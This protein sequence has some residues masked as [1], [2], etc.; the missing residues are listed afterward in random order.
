MFKH[1]YPGKFIVFEGV[2]GSGKFTQTRLLVKHLKQKGFKTAT[3]DFPQYGKKSAGLVEEYLNGKYGQAKEITPYQASI[4]YACDR[5]DA[6]F[7]VRRWLKQ[8][9]ILIADRY[10]GANVGHQ[11]GKIQNKRERTK[12]IRWLYNLEYNIFK[13]PRPDFNFVLNA[14]PSLCY[15]HIGRIDNK[16]KIAKK[17]IYLKN[18]TRDIHEK[19][20]DH[21]RDALGSY[22][23]LVQEFPRDF[24][25]INC[26]QGEKML[27]PQLIHE[28]IWKYVQKILRK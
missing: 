13:I 2:D 11:A 18:K 27:A 4:F 28:K 24:K 21:L 26:S 9:K 25:L 17:R 22:L 23:E 8:G 19:D 6:S 16:E 10:V 20:K 1:S 12:F 5:Y 7:K 15:R 3:I 14:L